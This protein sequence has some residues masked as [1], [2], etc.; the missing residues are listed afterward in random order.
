MYDTYVSRGISDSVVFFRR[1]RLILKPQ[2]T[3]ASKYKRL[4]NP[5]FTNHFAS[6]NDQAELFRPAGLNLIDMAEGINKYSGHCT[7]YTKSQYLEGIKKHFNFEAPTTVLED[8][9]F[10]AMEV[11]F[12]N[13]T[14]YSRVLTTDELL[15]CFVHNLGGDRRAN[16]SCGIGLPKRLVLIEKHMDE[17]RAFCDLLDNPH[18]SPDFDILIKVF[19]KDEMRETGKAT[20][21]I[22]VPQVHSWFVGMKLFG[23]LYKY[24]HSTDNATAFGIDN[25]IGAWTHHFMGFDKGPDVLTLSDDEGKQ[26]AREMESELRLA[27]EAIG[28]CYIKTQ[29]EELEQWFYNQM[30]SDKLMV[31]GYG[32]VL[33][34]HHG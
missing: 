24:L 7:F 29:Y 10:K 6:V 15:D 17:L 16:T 33:L 21:S 19:L 5:T 25:S 4:T 9:I 30:I 31:D 26:D 18:M 32:N 8:L 1:S 34:V 22:T 23:W 20:R 14:A 2:F 13:A 3:T 12:P 11:W 27:Y 28:C